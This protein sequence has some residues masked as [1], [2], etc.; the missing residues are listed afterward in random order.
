M[1]LD[2]PAPTNTATRYC[3]IVFKAEHTHAILI[4]ISSLVPYVLIYYA[5]KASR[6]LLLTYTAGVAHARTSGARG[7]GLLSSEQSETWAG[8]SPRRRLPRSS[9]RASSS[10]PASSHTK[11]STP[12]ARRS[13]RTRGPTPSEKVF[14]VGPTSAF[15]ISFIPTGMHGPSWIFWTFGPT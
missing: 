6:L 3:E 10:S 2:Q 4:V 9:V 5:N 1:K 12:G 7:G 8:S 13:G 15:Y 11:P 14:P